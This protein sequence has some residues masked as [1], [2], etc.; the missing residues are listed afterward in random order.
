[1]TQEYSVNLYLVSPSKLPIFAHGMGA[2]EVKLVR[3]DG[4]WM[5]GDSSGNRHTIM[6]KSLVMSR[7]SY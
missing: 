7:V 5:D 6:P 2:L 4:A 3:E 1:M